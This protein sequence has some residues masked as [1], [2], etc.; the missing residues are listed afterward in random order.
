MK[1]L[2]ASILLIVL[3]IG[4]SKKQPEPPYDVATITY[5]GAYAADGCGFWITID[6]KRYKPNN[7]SAIPDSFKTSSSHTITL[8]Y[9]LEQVLEEYQCGFTAPQEDVPT[10]EVVSI[11]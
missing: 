4:C 6:E 11:E 1:P 3:W 8:H 10:L 9:H 2:I 7:E 5:T